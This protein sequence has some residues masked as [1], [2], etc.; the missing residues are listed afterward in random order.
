MRR[1]LGQRGAIGLV[2]ILIYSAAILVVGTTMAV[3]S[4]GNYKISNE[5]IASVQSLYHAESG[6]EDA[7]MR[8]KRNSGYGNEATTVT[9]SFATAHR[10]ETIVETITKSGCAPAK[11]ITSSG[12]VD[13]LVRRIQM[14]NC[15]VPSPN[16]QFA[17]AL[18]A[19]T[20]G[21]IMDNNSTVLGSVYANG[22]I[23]GGNNAQ[24]TGD[25]WVAGAASPSASPEYD[26]S[27]TTERQIGNSA[28]GSAIDGAQSFTAETGSSATL[29]KVGLKI[30][31]VGNPANA[32]IRI[33]TD[34]NNKPSGTTLASGTLE[35]SRVG[36]G[37]SFVE[38]ALTSTPTLNDGQRYWL[39][40]DAN[41]SSTNYWGW[42]EAAGYADGKGATSAQWK[43]GGSMTWSDTNSDFAFKIFMG[44]TPTSLSGVQVAADAHANT[45]TNVN[46][47][48]D[49]Y[50]QSIANSTVART[51][52]PGTPD[53][54]TQNLPITQANVDDFKGMAVTGS[55]HIGNYTVPINSSATIG[56]M[57]IEG[58]LLLE[59]N[60]TL[61]LTGTVWVTGNVTLENNSYV[62]LDP[63]YTEGSGTIISDGLI[64]IVNNLTVNAPPDTYLMLLSTHTADN[65]VVINNNANSIV[66]GAPFGGIQVANNA[67]ANAIVANRLH[68]YENAVAT[69]LQG[70]SNVQFTN[71][72]GAS[73]A[74]Q[75]WHEVICDESDPPNCT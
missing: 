29:V 31:K 42:S 10:A 69:Y 16:I 66:L 30:L 39:V 64:N 68:L 24:I 9:T 1:R 48:R 11:K 49:A 35:A 41:S 17:Y 52:Y 72:P 5:R 58:D 12:F 51:S 56:P 54:P 20:G 74:A 3:T 70:L 75:G 18:Q 21:I 22:S 65:A 38:V 34:D 6:A 44:T 46:V 4:I 32:T 33:T 14:D 19:G 62:V 15:G 23:S 8:L 53:P 2:S 60:S 59:N 71:G 40:L 63:A 47:G 27:G 43:S 67:G 61:T 50:Y 57:K 36:T 13:T 45:I 26:P 55:T 73:F 25:A 37:A 28:N 7:L